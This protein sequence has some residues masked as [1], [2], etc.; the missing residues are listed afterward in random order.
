M[1]ITHQAQAQSVSRIEMESCVLTA[2]LS[3]TETAGASGGTTVFGPSPSVSDTATCA[4]NVAAD[5]NATLRVGYATSGTFTRIVWVNGISRAVSYPATPSTGFRTIDIPVVLNSGTNQV[6]FDLSYVSFDYVEAITTSP[7]TPVTPTTVPTPTTPALDPLALVAGRSEM[8]SCA[9]TNGLSPTVTTGASGGQTVFGPRPSI[10]DTATCTINSPSATNTVLRV[11]YSTGGAFS[12][13]VWVNGVQRI[14]AYPATP[15]NVYRTVDIPATLN[16]GSNQIRFDLSY[17]S[18]DYF[19]TT[20]STTVVTTPTNVTATTVAPT[21]ATTAP[22]TTAPPKP[23]GGRIEFEACALTAGLAATPTTGASGGSAVFGPRPSVS[24]IATC[25]VNSANATNS[26]LRVAYSTSGSLSR[27]V[28][29]NG[30]QRVVTYAATASNQFS[31]VDIPVSFIA[32]V[33]Q[34]QFDLSYISFD[35]FDTTTSTTVITTIATTAP[36]TT[37]APSPTTP[38]IPTSG[39][40]TPPA[41]PGITVDVKSTGATGNGVTDDTVAI[42]NAINKVADSG[43]GTVYFSAGVYIVTT[44]R[45]RVG[46]TYTGPAATIKRRAYLGAD[47]RN[48]TTQGYDYAGVGDSKPLVIRDLAFDGDNTHQGAYRGHEQEQS[49]LIFLHAWPTSPGRLKAYV[50]NVQVRNSVADGVSV[51]SNVDATVTNLT[52][53]NNYRGTIVATGG[54]TKLNI[55]GLNSS[56]LIDRVGFDS[57]IDGAGYGGSMKLEMTM[58]NSYIDGSIDIGLNGG[59]VVTI[60]N[61]TLKRG[62]FYVYNLNSTLTI[63]NS[64]LDIG[65]ADSVVNRIVAPGNITFDHVKFTVVNE[66]AGYQYGFDIYWSQIPT[67]IPNVVRC[68]YCTFVV[69][70]GLLPGL[71]VYGF[72]HRTIRSIDTFIMTNSTFGPGFTGS[73]IGS[74]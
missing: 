64:N 19:D 52:G 12:R 59:S 18:F 61:L 7:V 66:W 9:L 38:T 54:N 57:E 8:E 41:T 6:R 13:I 62:S 17:V 1:A 20:T 29:I 28:W 37:L 33:N 10:S 27:I 73:G 69:A 14:I 44:V 60:D 21:T 46:I 35:Y 53:S 56:G 42:Q 26:T 36:N 31:T 40:G 32:G 11:A 74:T 22:A 50:H 70:P 3:P 43:G 55:N 67:A 72:V 15:L 68:N 49:H 39:F 47:I 25:S 16:A 45:L 71:P 23:T 58:T 24:D 30:I 2:G 51:F 65:R 48:F 5:T 34:I 4:I 63:K